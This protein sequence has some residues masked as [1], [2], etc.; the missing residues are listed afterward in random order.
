M[1][2]F[3]VF[4]VLLNYPQ[5][6][7]L[8]ALPELE[9]ALA[10]EEDA[11]GAACAALAPLCA[12]LRAGP[13]IHLQEEYV[14]TFDRNPSHSLHLYEHIH[15]ESRERGPA[16]VRLMEEYNK[17]GLEIA[18]AELPDYLP[19]FLE[20]LSL[21]P[22]EQALVFLGEAVHVIAAVGRKLADNGS[23]YALVMRQLEALSPVAAE[24]LS[25]PPVKDM[26][27]AMELFGSGAD[28]L[29]PLLKPRPEASV[30][31]FHPMKRP[32]AAGLR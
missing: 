28:G 22:Q 20:F 25:E 13:L 11:N 19:L 17:L 16:L 15:G 5:E 26:D 27:E 21:L 9:E 8:A 23:P 14:A 6:D 10:A 31:N 30:V 29:E 18:E 7:W 2:S 24:A 1:Q 3:K 4:A 32:A 12:V